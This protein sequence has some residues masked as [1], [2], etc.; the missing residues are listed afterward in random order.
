MFCQKCGKEIPDGTKFCNY[1]GEPQKMVAGGQVNSYANH[2]PEMN[3]VS[4][5]EPRKSKGK[6]WKIIAVVAVILAIIGGVS[7]KKLQEKNQA[8]STP[9]VG[10]EDVTE[11]VVE[12]VKEDNP[13]FT[14]IFDERY[15][16]HMDEPLYGLESSVFAYVDETGLVDRVQIGY[17]ENDILCTFIETLYL[18]VSDMTQEQIELLGETM[19]SQ[20]SSLAGNINF[21]FEGKVLSKYYRYQ[22]KA[23][24]LDDST[25]LRQAVDAGVFTYDGFESGA[26]AS[27]TMTEQGYLDKGYIKK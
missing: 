22:I 17:N 1:C 24:N 13:E 15:I 3:Q 18:D 20:Y 16:V 12:E 25:I 2:T 10:T 21:E 6:T 19:D 8:S 5:K 23:E 27:G 7:Q 9:A 14:K 26:L 11:D 4:Y